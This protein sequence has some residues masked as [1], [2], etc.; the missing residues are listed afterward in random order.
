MK[1]KILSNTTASEAPASE[2][3]AGENI[4]SSSKNAVYVQLI[5]IIQY[6]TVQ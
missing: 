4:Q 6:Q 2:S 5:P 3:Y 1:L